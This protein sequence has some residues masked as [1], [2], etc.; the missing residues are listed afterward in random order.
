[1][2]R[3]SR[4]SRPHDRPRDTRPQENPPRPP[5]VYLVVPKFFPYFFS[6]SFSVAFTMAFTTAFLW[7]LP[8]SFFEWLTCIFRV[9]CLMCV[10]VVDLY[11]FWWFVIYSVVG[12][13]SFVLT[14]LFGLCCCGC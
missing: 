12:V 7:R 8:S 11:A 5:T 10:L 2:E 3:R 14:M 1:M 4:D 9:R 13:Y 6:T